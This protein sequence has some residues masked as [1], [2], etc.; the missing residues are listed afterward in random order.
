M[1]FICI[2]N[3][4]ADFSIL[5][6]CRTPALN[7]E[8][9]RIAASLR[10]NRIQ[11]VTIEMQ[12]VFVEIT[13]KRGNEKYD[14]R[15]EEK[16]KM[17]EKYSIPLVFID[18]TDYPDDFGKTQTHLEYKKLR[19]LLQRISCGYVKATGQFLTPY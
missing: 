5:R 2:T 14:K 6:A 16:R 18:M 11:K 1:G 10:G 17:A 4:R 19:K 3:L 15:L 8:S 12:R 9:N 7:T 13:G